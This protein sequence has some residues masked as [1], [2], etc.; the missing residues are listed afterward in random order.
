MNNINRFL[1]NRPIPPK[2]EFTGIFEDK[3]LIVILLESVNDIFIHEEYFPTFYY[4]FNNGISFRNNYTPRNSCS[5]GNNEMT[6]MTGL[7]SINNIC[8]VNVYNQ[9]R[10][11]QSIFN[12]FNRQDYHTSSYHNHGD[13]FYNRTVI[14]RNMGSSK[15]FGP[16]ALGIPWTTDFGQWASDLTLM[17]RSM[18]H[19]IDEDPYMAFITTVTPHRA[20]TVYSVYAERHAEMFANQGFSRPLRRYLSKLKELDLA[21]EYM[22]KNLEAEGQ[23]ENTVIAMFSDHYPHGLTNA[24]INEFLDY[25]V[26]VRREIDRT[27]MV[28]YHS[29]TP[30]KQVYKYSTIIDLLPTLLNMFN[31]QH[32]PRHYFGID[33]MSQQASRAIF[34]DGSWQD[35]IGFYSATSGRFTPTNNNDLTYTREELIEINNHIS[36]MKRMSGG[37][38]RN[39]YFHQLF[40]AKERFRPAQPEEEQIITPPGC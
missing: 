33:L 4:L 39:N 8:T 27:P 38:I 14:H 15:F 5:T 21:L 6:A 19:F 22:L 2:N 10:Y 18:P 12:V 25:D 11:P 40:R 35:E 7:F 9:N 37:I 31:T 1:I 29:G 30:A 20:Y 32:D 23:L 24:Q 36:S 28:I 16:D 13:I 26:N 34:A 17:Q 3:N